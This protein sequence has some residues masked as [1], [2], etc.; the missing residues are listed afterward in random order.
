MR[1]VAV[2]L[3]LMLSACGGGSDPETPKK[4]TATATTTK[5]PVKPT[6]AA[7]TGTPAP[8]ALSQFQCA[9]DAKGVWN[10][11]GTIAN[12]GKT[13]ATFQVTVYV[14][15][16]AGSDEQALTKQLP[17]IEAGG[18]VKFAVTK[19]PAPKAGGPCHVQVLRR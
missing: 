13:K 7:P 9:K 16:A 19:V 8:E 17:N 10:A 1:T 5:A 18:S 6:I 11:S 14:G 2:A 3:I 4:P 15:E 12:N